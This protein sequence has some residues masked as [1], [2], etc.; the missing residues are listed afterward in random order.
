MQTINNSIDPESL[1]WK[2]FAGEASED[3]KQEILAWVK[4]SEANKKSFQASREA[5]ISAKH[6]A[7]ET[8]FDSAAAHQKFVRSTAPAR[9]MTR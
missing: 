9:R 3:E 8:A 5:Y 6:S 2:F 7:Q 4:Q 1:F